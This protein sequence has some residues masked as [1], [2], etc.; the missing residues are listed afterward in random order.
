MEAVS[1]DLTEWS[2]MKVLTKGSYGV[3]CVLHN[4]GQ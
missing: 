3:M 2:N 4:W 1:Y